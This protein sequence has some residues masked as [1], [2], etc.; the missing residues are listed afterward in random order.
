MKKK[1]PIEKPNPIMSIDEECF[2]TFSGLIQWTE[3]VVLQ[4]K[5]VATAT[6]QLMNYENGTNSFAKSINI[7]HCEQHYFVI[8][9]NKLYEYREWIKIFG[10]FNNVDFSEIDSFSRQDI[11][12]L[13][14]M[15]EH[16]IDYFHGNGKDKARWVIDTPEYK[17]DASSCVGTMIGG[18]LDYIKFANAA[19]RLLSE[20]LKETI[21][22]PAH[23]I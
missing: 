14:N 22:Y 11:K 17:A 18:R 2:M 10:L 9:A 6:E 3:G 7:L 16:V 12:D 5:R 1:S 15:R 8:A 19:E 20:L 23:I 21:P 13:R 4:S